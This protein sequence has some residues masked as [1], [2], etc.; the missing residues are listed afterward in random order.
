MTPIH[1]VRVSYVSDELTLVVK[2]NSP[3]MMCWFADILMA[4]LATMSMGCHLLVALLALP[5]VGST[6]YQLV[7]PNDRT[8]LDQMLTLVVALSYI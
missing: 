3:V 1:T 2:W 6:P 7:L 4:D 5:Y 8:A